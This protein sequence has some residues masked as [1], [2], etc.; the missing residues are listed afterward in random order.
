MIAFNIEMIDLQMF[1]VVFVRTGAVLMSI[2]LLGDRS[3]PVLLKAGLALA[4]SFVLFPAVRPLDTVLPSHGIPFAI[5]ICGEILL[6]I[7]VGLFVRLIFAGVQLAGQMAGYQ[8]GLAIAN[9]LDPDSN[10]QIPLLGQFYNLLAILIFVTVDAHH[11]VVRA[12]VDSFRIAPPLTVTLGH[13]FM[14]QLVRLSA[15]LF[16]IGIKVG[17]P[18]IAVLLITSV[19][20]GLIAR[21]VPQMNIFIV[22][23][24]FK[25]AVGLLFMA[26]SAP[27]VV[28]LLV[29]I[30]GDLGTGLLN[31]F[32]AMH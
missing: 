16:V 8:M 18:V 23:I 13:S 4:V 11:Q 12:L 27:F 9:V 32:A 2:P 29:D 10:D 21:T 1:L 24:P 19:A 25:V 15:D 30:F 5:G 7:S 6:G 14:E 17:A 3:L 28:T 26:L 31:L 22:A 20:F